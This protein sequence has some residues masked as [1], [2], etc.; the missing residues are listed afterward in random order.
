MSIRQQQR[1]QRRPASIIKLLTMSFNSS[2]PRKMKRFMKNSS[3]MLE[4]IAHIHAPF[5]YNYRLCIHLDSFT[6][7]RQ[8]YLVDFA[9]LGRWSILVLDDSFLVGA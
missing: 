2:F 3:D 8:F 5:S 6:I 4:Y 1:L 7:S 9:F